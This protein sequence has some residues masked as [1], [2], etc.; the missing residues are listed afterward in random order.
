MNK[1]IF[2]VSQYREWLLLEQKTVEVPYSFKKI[3]IEKPKKKRKKF[4]FQGYINFQGIEIDVENMPGSVRK[5]VD[6]DGTPWETK[7]KFAYGEARDTETVDGDPLDIYVGLNY[8]S[9]LVVIVN[10]NDPE[11]GK[12]DEQKCFVGF[13]DEEE[14][15]KAYKQHYDEPEKFYGSH[16]SMNIG[17]FWRWVHDERQQ[18]KK[19][20]Q[21]SES[22]GAHDDFDVIFGAHAKQVV[23]EDEKSQGMT[24]EEIIAAVQAGKCLARANL[25]GASLQRVDLPEVD[26]YKANLQGANLQGANLYGANLQRANLQRASLQKANLRG[27]YLQEANLQ[28]A[29]LQEADLLFMLAYR[30]KTTGIKLSWVPKKGDLVRAYLEYLNSDKFTLGILLEDPDPNHIFNPISIR[31]H[32]RELKPS[33][34]YMKPA[35]RLEEIIQEE[36]KKEMIF[37]KSGAHHVS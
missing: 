17:S 10:Q 19:V 29:D 11:T 36:L 25:R 33:I 7:M 28:E 8:D 18:G 21:I 6:E 5:G 23:V 34:T 4:P 30:A 35:S 12:F 32:D 2:D 20:K 15:V 26:L 22:Q 14:A 1:E 24:R 27:V 31:L 9:P 37:N 13:D 16:F 3:A